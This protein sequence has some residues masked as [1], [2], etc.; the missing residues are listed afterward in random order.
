MK[1]YEHLN[2]LQ[3]KVIYCDTDSVIYSA[4]PG[5][6]K[7]PLGN[8]L[9]ELTNELDA[10]DYITEFVSS[11]PKA[12]AYVTAQGHGCTKLKGF[13]LNHTNAQKINYESMKTLVLEG[14]YI[15]T[16]NPSK[17]C[18]NKNDRT[19]YNVREEKKYQVVYDKR[20]VQKDLSTLPFG[21]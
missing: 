8:Y 10:D 4:K 20:V 12:Y 7:L 9:G 21:Y 3:E 11:G 15:T 2:T 19:I 1:L 13:T 6:R 14:G 16:F 5:E 18:R 17:I